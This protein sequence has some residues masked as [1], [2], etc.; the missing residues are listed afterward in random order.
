[1]VKP[2][3]FNDET[4]LV[5]LLKRELPLTFSQPLIVVLFD[6]VVKPGT[7]NDGSNVALSYK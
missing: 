1:M 5:M 3:T 6:K 4:N 7:F 2:D